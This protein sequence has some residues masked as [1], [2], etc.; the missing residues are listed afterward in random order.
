MATL[1]EIDV[2]AAELRAARER[3]VAA[4]AGSPELFAKHRSIVMHGIKAGFRQRPSS[5]SWEDDAVLIASIRQH[6]PEQ[7]AK[8]VEVTETP[9]KDALAELVEETLRTLGVKVN[10]AG[11]RVI[12]KFVEAEDDKQLALDLA[13]PTS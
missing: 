2:I 9:K 5:L 13:E 12:A 7:F 8:L 3:L 1:Q 4:I 6:L 10:P 11:M